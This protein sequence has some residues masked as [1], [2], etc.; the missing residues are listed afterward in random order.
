MTDNAELLPCGWR[1]V[2]V[3]PTE[4]MLEAAVSTPTHWDLSSPDGPA[5]RAA[6]QADRAVAASHYRSMLAAAPASTSSPVNHLTPYLDAVQRGVKIGSCSGD[7]ACGGICPTCVATNAQAAP[8]AEEVLAD[9]W[10]VEWKQAG[11]DWVDAHADE[12]RAVDQARLKGGICTPLYRGMAAALSKPRVSR[13]EIARALYEA[14]NRSPTCWRWDDGGLDDEHPGVRNRY[15]MQA[16]AIIALIGG[17]S[18][19][20]KDAVAEA[21]ANSHIYNEA[22]DSDPRKAVRDLIACEV[23][24]ALDPA[25]SAR[26]AALVASGGRK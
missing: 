13:E 19:P 6:V 11:E 20:W 15:Y 4:A 8:V 16:D 22:H 1:L 21:L 7:G 5:M 10:L 9:A 2:P 25:V 18:N 14:N 3:E 24:T 17:G 26:A 12:V 23:D